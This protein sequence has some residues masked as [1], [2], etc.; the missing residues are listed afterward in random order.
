[1]STSDAYQMDNFMGKI[2]FDTR[3]GTKIRQAH[4]VAYGVFDFANFGGDISSTSFN[5]GIL[6]PDNAVVRWA[7]FEILTSV[8]SGGST[9]LCFQTGE[10][11][12][13]LHAYQ[14]KASWATSDAFQE[15]VPDNEEGNFI[16]LTA[17]RQIKAVVSG[18][19]VTAGKIKVYLDYILSE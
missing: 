12:C 3:M 9:D 19:S 13:D 18:A 16:K 6:L 8:T 1:M 10:S 4:N 2:P 5:V 11:A 17:A 7:M 14:A 15:G